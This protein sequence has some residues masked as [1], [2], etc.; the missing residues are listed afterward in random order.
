MVDIIASLAMLFASTLSPPDHNGW[1]GF[2][3]MSLCR[4]LFDRNQVHTIEGAHEQ[5]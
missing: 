1:N 3:N 5:D 2:G 4:V